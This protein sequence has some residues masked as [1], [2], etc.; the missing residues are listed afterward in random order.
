M[1]YDVKARCNGTIDDKPCGR[2]LKMKASASSEVTI[3]CP[4][5]KCKAENKIKVV[6]LSD[7]VKNQSN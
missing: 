1:S 7:M 4:D 5:R 3:T 2:F 6:M